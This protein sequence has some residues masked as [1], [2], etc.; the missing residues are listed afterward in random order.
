MGEASV[1]AGKSNGK[2]RTVSP[3]MELSVKLAVLFPE[4]EEAIRAFLASIVAQEHVFVIGPPG[5]GKSALVRAI[6]G[7]MNLSHYFEILMSRTTAPDE[8]HGPVKVSG[9]KN[10]KF[11]RAIDG[12][13]PTAEVIDLEEVWKGSSAILNTLLI[14]LNER[15]FRQGDTWVNIP[16]VSC[17]AS[18]N[19][20]PENEELDALYD[21]FL[22]RLVVD[23][24]SH[25]A[26]ENVLFD[27]D[28]VKVDPVAPVVEGL[29]VR[30]EHDKAMLITFPKPVREAIVNVRR[31]LKEAGFTV[32]DRRFKRALKLV[33]AVAHMDGRT[34]ADV[35]DLDILEHVLWR[36]PDERVQVAKILGKTVSPH[37]AAAVECVDAAQQAFQRFETITDV[38][39]DIAQAA[40]INT[41]L[42]EIGARLD[43]LPA[44]K[45]VNEAKARVAAYRQTVSTA[46]RKAAGL[47]AFG[48]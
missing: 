15:K 44:S 20:L 31:A 45:K 40:E 10:D 18:S 38:A 24:V 2:G 12:Y 36:K 11:E 6:A 13:L 1:V 22:V 26:F 29:D 30:A 43:A 48:E 23:Y 8:V 4:R 21:R 35:D 9:L 19:E 34:V 3:L 41:D 14:A 32:S 27:G 37:A 25:E 39:T 46:V 47:E 7:A 17:F 33:Q 16:L 5:T 28:S 42:K